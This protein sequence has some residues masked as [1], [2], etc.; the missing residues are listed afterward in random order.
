MME[1]RC[2]KCHGWLEHIT[3]LDN[4]WKCRECGCMHIYIEYPMSE[5]EERLCNCL[6]E[7]KALI[8]QNQNIFEK[9]ISNMKGL[10]AILNKEFGHIHDYEM[11]S[12]LNEYRQ[13]HDLYVESEEKVNYL[14]EKYKASNFTVGNGYF[15]LLQDFANEFK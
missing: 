13:M 9:C 12:I 3:H 1:P 2:L 15:E 8:L 7:A 10:I 4:I 5:K 14:I 11:V 6:D